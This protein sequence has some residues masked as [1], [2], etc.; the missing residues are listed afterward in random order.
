MERS[1]SERTHYRT[2]AQPE[3]IDSLMLED[4]DCSRVAGRADY[5]MASEI[6]S[7]MVQLR[8]SFPPGGRSCHLPIC[9]L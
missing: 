1:C 7:Q 6:D 4:P 3:W 9:S 2:D 8:Q 5:L